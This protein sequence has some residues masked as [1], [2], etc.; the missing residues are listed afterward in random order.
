[1][2][3]SLHGMV[4]YGKEP[5][6]STD[7]KRRHILGAFTLA[8][9]LPCLRDVARHPPVLIAGFHTATHWVQPSHWLTYTYRAGPFLDDSAD[10]YESSAR[11]KLGTPPGHTD[12]WSVGASRPSTD[13][14]VLCGEALLAQSAGRPYP[15]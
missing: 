14:T 13:S 2:V 12:P 5:S 10:S 11:A 4:W 8:P 7:W 15:S 3:L 1:M 6:F 9:T